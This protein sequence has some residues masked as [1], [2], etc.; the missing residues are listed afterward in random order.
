VEENKWGERGGRGVNHI[1]ISHP[2]TC[3]KLVTEVVGMILMFL[4][5]GLHVHP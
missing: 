1:Y 3:D 5:K 4:Q 2:E